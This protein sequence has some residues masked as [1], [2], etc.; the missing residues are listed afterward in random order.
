MQ[1]EE[2]SSRWH[3]Y[4]FGPE[5]RR[6][7]DTLLNS[8]TVN[9]TP[10]LLIEAPSQEKG[11]SLVVIMSAVAVGVLVALVAFAGLMTWRVRKLC[12]KVKQLEKETVEKSARSE[13]GVI[14]GDRNLEWDK[15]TA[16]LPINKTLKFLE[17]MEA[18]GKL[19]V[20]KEA[21]ELRRIMKTF[22]PDLPTALSALAAKEK[23]IP[24]VNALGQCACQMIFPPSVLRCR[25]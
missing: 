1:V 15:D 24:A 16:E 10:V 14:P 6:R 22:D 2:V 13:R 25:T 7:I 11:S 3:I 20:R 8:V 5:H 18:E 21:S 17:K 9:G 12:G 23:H 4:H 19:G